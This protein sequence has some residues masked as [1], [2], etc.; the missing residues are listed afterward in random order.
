M[1]P[2]SACSLLSCDSPEAAVTLRSL[3]EGPARDCKH[4]APRPNLPQ[5]SPSGRHDTL[6]CT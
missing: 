1:D 6:L 5:L 2:F 3:D 4:Q